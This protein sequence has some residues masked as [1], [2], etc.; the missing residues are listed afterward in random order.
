M[1]K[2]VNWIQ[3][4]G[5]CEYDN[6]PSGYTHTHTHTHTVAIS[7]ILSCNDAISAAERDG[8]VDMNSVN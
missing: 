7:P 8:N 1:R 4:A 2:E 5:V 6:K 3:L